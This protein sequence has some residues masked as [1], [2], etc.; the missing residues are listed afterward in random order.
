MESWGAR[1]GRRVLAKACLGRQ[2]ADNQKGSHRAMIN[3]KLERAVQ[4]PTLVDFKP[5]ALAMDLAMES[6]TEM[7]NMAG[8]E[9]GPLMDAAVPSRRHHRHGAAPPLRGH[10]HPLQA[11]AKAMVMAR[12]RRL[13]RLGRRP[14]QAREVTFFLPRDQRLVARVARATCFQLEREAAFFS[15]TM[16]AEKAGERRDRY[17]F[18]NPIYIPPQ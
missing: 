15:A 8:R 12:E 17:C 16:L 18:N 13:D 10:R 5:K 7:G 9:K 2:L 14:G 3:P 1:L 4:A 6:P 11:R